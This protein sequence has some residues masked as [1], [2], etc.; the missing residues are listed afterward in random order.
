[1]TGAIL[2]LAGGA[3]IGYFPAY[4]FVCKMYDYLPHF[5]NTLPAPGIE[6]VLI[7]GIPAVVCG[8]FG[9]T[10]GYRVGLNVGREICAAKRT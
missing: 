10:R 6:G 4:L 5:S 2:G 1:M 3:A 8:F 9:L 7:I